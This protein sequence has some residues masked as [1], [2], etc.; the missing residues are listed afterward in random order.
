M[1]ANRC[2]LHFAVQIGLIILIALLLGSPMAAASP[3][4]H[5]APPREAAAYLDDP[6]ATPQPSFRVESRLPLRTAEIVLVDGEYVT[7]GDRYVALKLGR[8]LRLAE[9]EALEGAGVQ[10]LSYLGNDVMLAGVEPGALSANVIAT[11]DIQAATPWQAQHKASSAVRRG[12]A[13]AWAQTEEGLLELTVLFFEDVAPGEMEQIL[14]RHALTYAPQSPPLLWAITIE[15]AKLDPLLQESGIHLIEPGPI[16]FSPLLDEARALIHVDQVQQ[17]VIGNNP[18][19][20]HYDGLTGRGV[21]LQVSEDVWDEHPDFIDETGQTRFLDPSPASGS[22]HGTLVAGIMAGDGELSAERQDTPFYAPIGRWRGMAPEASLYEG[23]YSTSTPA[24]DASNHSYIMSYGDY[25][26]QSA[27]VD[28]DISGDDGADQQW[29]QVWAAGNNGLLPQHNDE[30]GYYSMYAPAKNSIA[31]GSVNA[32]DG[33]L[34]PFS[35][36]GPTFDGRIKPDVM[37]PGGKNHLPATFDVDM[38]RIGMSIDFIRIYNSRSGELEM[39]WEFNESGNTEG[40]FQSDSSY[41]IFNVTTG[42][43]SLNFQLGYARDA[44][45]NQDPWGWSGPFSLRANPDQSVVMR[46]KM[47]YP[48]DRIYAAGG[49]QWHIQGESTRINGKIQFPVTCTGSWE[50]VEIP[51]GRWGQD[52]SGTHFTGWN[53]TIE[54][55]LLIPMTHN[56]PGVYSVHYDSDTGYAAYRSSQGTSEAAPAV[57][58]SIALILQQL[59]DVHGVDL[60]TSPPLP[61]TIKAILIQT[62]T[63]LVH[64]FG[65]PRDW[66]NPDTGAPVVYDRGP[67]FATG[68]GLV[69]IEAAVTMIAADPGPEAAT[70]FMHEGVLDSYQRHI[71]D[72]SLS[73]TDLEQADRAQEG[74]LVQFTLVWD[75][76]A[77]DP[78]AAQT[79]PKLVNDLDLYLIDPAGT[80]HRPWT[81]DPL[82]YAECDGSG[83]G[84]GDIDPI[85][86]YAIE[87]A[88]R[89]ADHRNNV[90]MV[91]V[92]S[93]LPGRWQLVVE[94]YDVPFPAQSYSLVGSQLSRPIAPTALDD[95]FAAVA[96]TEL[97]VQAPGILANDT[98]ASGDPRVYFMVEDYLDQANHIFGQAWTVDHWS[99]VDVTDAA[100]A[101]ATT[102]SALSVTDIAGNP[103]IY[104]A[105]EGAAGIHVHELAWDGDRWLHEDVTAAARGPDAEG[106]V[107]VAAQ[108]DGAP[109]VYHLATGQNGLHVIELSWQMD[110]WTATDL[111]TLVQGPPARIGSALA[112]TTVVNGEPQVYYFSTDAGVQELSR[113]G[114]GWRH[115]DITAASGGAQAANDSALSALAVAGAARVY[116]VANAMGNQHIHELAWVDESW[117]DSD[118]TAAVAGAPDATG[119]ALHAL[120]VGTQEDPRVY[121]MAEGYYEWEIHELA[122]NGSGWSHKNL[123]IDGYASEALIG[124]PLFALTVKHDPRVYFQVSTMD[125]NHIHELAWMDSSWQASDVSERAGGPLSVAAVALE[126]C[127]ANGGSL[128]A[129]LVR[130]TQHGTLLLNADGSFRYTPENGYVGIDSFAYTANHGAADS[131]EVTVRIRIRPGEAGQAYS[132]LPLIHR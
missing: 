46:Y 107:L 110:H 53:G 98:S 9:I 82:P 57:T 101:P 65:D 123:T 121:Y 54:Q 8:N 43:G 86:P 112:V 93:P 111:T 12:E 21:T 100:N 89:D 79:T 32:N 78:T 132:Y 64:S 127:T 36:L 19:S 94:A 81:L 23:G 129:R 22:T 41:N 73:E 28:R 42:G 4:T 96:D 109:H 67:D 2:P 71:Y 70:R 118:L 50:V 131:D 120:T 61:S 14:N 72:F 74:D 83:P 91:E 130:D 126:G 20:I 39:A 102:H 88:R 38:D 52:A 75:D 10:L 35:S 31:V 29:P 116:Y 58:G 92:D 80:I 97:L 119:D 84:C 128:T 62:A 114:A 48:P 99:Y 34:S 76:R 3:P 103:R 85:P 51:V 15:P 68:Y 105:A 66:N 69:D 117:H 115:L 24:I 6:I 108:I 40:W 27:M 104:Y 1:C 26:G 49:L 124:S 16:P 47:D 60:Q 95:H 30:E 125:G 44:A 122:W 56:W 13:P 5:G 106:G 90:E 63:D 18:P 45:G 37:A 11:Y 59:R 55:F 17:A 7:S 33:G 113:S 25:D 77:G 87:P